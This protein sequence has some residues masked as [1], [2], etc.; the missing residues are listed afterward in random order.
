V[1]LPILVLLAAVVLGVA[2]LYGLGAWLSGSRVVAN[3]TELV[4]A[5]EDGLSRSRIP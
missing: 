5:D 2:A 3:G 4:A 1:Y